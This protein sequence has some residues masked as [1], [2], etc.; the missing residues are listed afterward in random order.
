TFL[1]NWDG[2]W[3]W[4]PDPSVEW[5]FM[6]YSTGV[7]TVDTSFPGAWAQ[8]TATEEGQFRIDSGLFTFTTH[9][10][11]ADA[12][13]TD[14]VDDYDGTQTEDRSIWKLISFVPAS[15]LE[16]VEGSVRRIWTAAFVLLMVF[17]VGVSWFY[18]RFNV[19]RAEHRS[20]VEHLAKYDSLTGACNRHYFEQSIAD[21]QARA[22][23]YKHPISFLMI[24]IT[25]F[26]QINDTY[27]HKVGDE[28]LE[29]VAAILKTSVRETDVVVRYG[30]DEFLIM[31]PE[32]AGEADEARQRILDAI[33]ELN[34]DKSKFDFSVLLAMGSAQWDPAD[35]LTIEDVLSYADEQMYEHKQSQHKKLDGINSSGTAN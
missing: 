23:R 20:R 12:T 30:G 9:Y 4:G 17:A 7:H 28:V 32:T 3:L 31:F 14:V 27:G 21:E 33:E 18:A 24:D 11:M 1:A 22:G 6:Y 13:R 35:G 16:A 26:K 8:L 5:G 29:E 25:R 19:L 10:P 34:S 15:V 2:Y